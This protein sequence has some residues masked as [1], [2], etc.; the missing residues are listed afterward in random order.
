VEAC[1]I[2]IHA[3]EMLNYWRRVRQ[4]ARAVWAVIVEAPPNKLPI[5]FA[6]NFNLPVLAYPATQFVKKHAD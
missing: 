3:V 5:L 4:V 1:A 6:I 2:A